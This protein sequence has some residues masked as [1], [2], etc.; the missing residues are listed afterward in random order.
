MSDSYTPQIR[1]APYRRPIATLSSFSGELIRQLDWL[2][3]QEHKVEQA[4]TEV[5]QRQ[6]AGQLG[7]DRRAIDGIGRV[8]IEVDAYSYH[9]WGQ[10]LSYDCWQDPSFLREFERDNPHARVKCGGTRIQSG[11]R[12]LAPAAP[13]RQVHILEPA[14]GRR[15]WTKS[16]GT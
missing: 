1:G 9:Y 8:R 15:R 5:R 14:P 11:Y 13:S 12:G 4:L 7:T 16:Y 6:A 2:F 10:R 3:R